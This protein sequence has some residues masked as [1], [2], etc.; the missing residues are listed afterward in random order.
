MSDFW[1]ID[2]PYFG[3]T[4]CSTSV[5]HVDW[6]CHETALVMPT[7]GAC[8][9]RCSGE[10]P[11]RIE[12]GPEGLQARD[13]EN[14]DNHKC[15][16][17]A[18]KESMGIKGW[19]LCP[20]TPGVYRFGPRGLLAPEGKA[21]PRSWTK[22]GRGCIAPF[23]IAGRSGCPPAEPYPARRSDHHEKTGKNVK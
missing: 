17:T 6:R 18:K 12:V 22:A 13:Y 21:L 19:G 5:V 16:C 10:N 23:G 3:W 8:G 2:S 7:E 9:I 20:Q 15:H 4:R 14:A 11:A 1:W